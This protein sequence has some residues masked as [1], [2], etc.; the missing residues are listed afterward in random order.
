[1]TTFDQTFH[2]SD[3]S[4]SATYAIED[5]PEMQD[6]YGARRTFRPD[7]LV[8]VDDGAQVTHVSIRGSNLK[9]DG[10]LGAQEVGKRW[11]NYGISSRGLALPEWL[12]PAVDKHLA[13]YAL[14]PDVLAAVRG[15]EGE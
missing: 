11:T 3:Y 6:D 9:K 8:I 12:Q 1:M 4:N 7:T 15:E 2:R 13:R 10:T 14:A 5:G